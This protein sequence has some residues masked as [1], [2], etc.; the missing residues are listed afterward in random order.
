MDWVTFFL[1]KHSTID[2]F[3]H[4]GTMMLPYTGFPQFNK[5]FN[6]V[7]QWSSAEVKE[8]GVEIVLVF[9]VTPSNASASQSIPFAEALI[10][11]QNFVWFHHCARY[12]CN[13]EAV[14]EYMEIYLEVF[15]HHKVV[16]S[17]FHTS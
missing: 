17:R 11:I 3:K 10:C 13:T 16:F 8:L 15:H 12:R 14:I 6:V 9:A 5:P 4:L 7:I 2:Q 1:E